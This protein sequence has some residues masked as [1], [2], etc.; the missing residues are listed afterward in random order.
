M[1]RRRVRQL[2]TEDEFLL[3][4]ETEERNLVVLE[5]DE[6]EELAARVRKV[7]DKYRDLGRRQ[8]RQSV[9]RHGARGVVSGANSATH[10]KAE[11]FAAA[12]E[13]VRSAQERT[14]RRVEDE[15]RAARLD[16]VSSPSSPPAGLSPVRTVRRGTAGGFQSSSA[17]LGRT[18]RIRR[19]QANRTRHGAA[20]GRV[21]QARRDGRP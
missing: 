13:R 4:L 19:A 5:L 10:D 18:D 11:V 15:E 21:K 16:A 8:Q 3:Y 17:A 1:S 20:R 12:L 6:F 9:D 14:Q 2:C 7:A